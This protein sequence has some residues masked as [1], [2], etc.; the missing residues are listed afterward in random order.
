MPLSKCLCL[1]LGTVLWVQCGT[2]ERGQS[3]CELHGV[4]LE[5]GLGWR[6]RPIEH[7]TPD[8]IQF[9][10]WYGDRFPHASS[11]PAPSS[12]DT[13]VLLVPVEFCAQCRS[14]LEQALLEAYG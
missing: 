11:F 2:T 5:Q 8:Q 9:V 12:A 10:D 1:L 13:E 3:T 14:A 4:D 6:Q 7:M